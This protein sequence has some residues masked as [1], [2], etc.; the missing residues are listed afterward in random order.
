MTLFNIYKSI[1]YSLDGNV[2]FS[3]MQAVYFHPYYF[4]E[5]LIRLLPP[6]GLMLNNTNLSALMFCEHTLLLQYIVSYANHVIF[7]L[8]Q[9]VLTA[10][11][12]H[13]MCS[14]ANRCS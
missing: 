12:V 14:N 4:H 5:I 2:C 11:D 8:F 3:C 9:K 1:D 6:F 10:T 13:Y 7:H